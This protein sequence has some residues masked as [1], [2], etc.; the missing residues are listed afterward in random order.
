MEADANVV[1]LSLNSTASSA[2]VLP[3]TFEQIPSTTRHQPAEKVEL[4][5]YLPTRVSEV[6]RS[7]SQLTPSGS[8]SRVAVNRFARKMELEKPLI[9]S[10][11]TPEISYVPSVSSN[12]ASKVCCECGIDERNREVKRRKKLDSIMSLFCISAY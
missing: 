5:S 2:S 4:S 11:V 9:S 12:H 8:S 6:S 3:P 7:A 10:P 1:S